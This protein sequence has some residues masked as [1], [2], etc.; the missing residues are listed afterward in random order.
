MVAPDRDEDAERDRPSVI[1]ALTPAEFQQ[2]RTMLA[3]WDR[4]EKMIIAHERAEWFWSSLGLWLKWMAGIA[5]ALVGA[6]LLLSDFR[7][8]LKGW[9]LK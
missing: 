7:D 6:K 8:I 1:L 2:L 5:A 9:L 4:L 3:S